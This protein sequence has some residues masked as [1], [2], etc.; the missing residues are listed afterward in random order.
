LPEGDEVPTISFAG[1]G[2][3]WYFHFLAIDLHYLNFCCLIFVIYTVFQDVLSG[4]R[5]LHLHTF[6]SFSH[7]NSSVVCWFLRR[8][9][10]STGSRSV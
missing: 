1:G 4:R 2:M 7:Q 10:F 3:L 8:H 5:S 6:R 9:S